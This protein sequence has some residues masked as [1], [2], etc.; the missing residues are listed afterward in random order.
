MMEWRELYRCL[1]NES[2]SLWGQE[3]KE[4]R[5]NKKKGSIC[6]LVHSQLPLSSSPQLDSLA[7]L[8]KVNEST[9]CWWSIGSKDINLILQFSWSQMMILRPELEQSL[10][11][12]PELLNPKCWVVEPGSLY[13]ARLPGDFGAC[14]SL[15]HSA[16]TYLY[17]VSP[18]SI[19]IY[20]SLLY[21][22]YN[23]QSYQSSVL[24]WFF[25][26]VQFMANLTVVSISYISNSFIAKT[27]S[28]SILLWIFFPFLI[29][30]PPCFYRI[31]KSMKE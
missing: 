7:A 3:M 13:L 18:L 29:T 15:R 8:V 31:C 30:L 23:V 2:R 11:L 16:V 14:L 17:S 27:I 12:H 9:K 22:T 19:L 5:K 26:F 10:W 1:R 4:G 25:R 28:D 21:I 24:P 20:C 6:S